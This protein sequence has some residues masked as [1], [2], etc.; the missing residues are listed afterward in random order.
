[1]IAKRFFAAFIL[2]FLFC[3]PLSAQISVPNYSFTGKEISDFKVKP[4]YTTVQFNFSM[5]NPI[6][7]Y[8]QKRQAELES[9]D[10]R[11]YSSEEPGFIYKDPNSARFTS[12]FIGN[13]ALRNNVV[14]LFLNKSYVDVVSSYERF[15][16]KLDNSEFADEVRFLYGVSLYYIGSQKDALQTLSKLAAGEGEYAELAQDALFTAAS[17]LKL[18]DVMENAASEIDKFTIFSLSKWLEYLYSKDRYEDILSLLNNY[19]KLEADYP[20]YKVMR[21]TCCYFLKRYGEMEKLAAEI[22]DK[23]VLP[24]IADAYIMSGKLDE[25]KKII[26]KMD[27]G[28]VKL[29]LSAKIDINNKNFKSASDKAAAMASDN[30]KLALFFYAVSERFKAI[31]PDF[32]HSFRFKN[33]ADNDYVYFYTGLKYF[34][35]K[36]YADAVHYFSLIGFNKSLMNTASFYKGMAGLHID[37]NISEW[38]FKK[39][40]NTGGDSDKIALAKFML[41]QIYYLKENYDD[42]LML[43]DD[44][45]EDYC[46]VLKADLYLAANNGEKAFE[47][48]KNR[49][50]DRSRLIKANVYYNDKKYKSALAE[51]VKIKKKNADS[52]YLLMMSLF[53]NKRLKDAEDV[54]KANKKDLRIFSN[55]VQQLILAGEGRKALAYMEGIDNLSPAFKL[56]RAKLLA[57]YNRLKEAKRDYNALIVDNVFIYEALSG[58]FEIAKKEKKGKDFVEEKLVYVEK[59]GD[60][61]NK[62]VLVAELASYALEADAPNAAIGYVNYFL[63]NYP[64]SERYS[65]VLRTR[66]KLFRFTGRFENC[67][68]D[69]D[70]IIAGGGEAGEDALFM[71]AECLENIDKNKAVETYKTVADT[72]KRF[73]VPALAKVAAM[74]NNAEDVFQASEKLKTSSPKQWRTGILRFMDLSGKKD[75]EKHKEYVEELSKSSLPAVR[76]AA[77]WRIGKDEFESGK[78]ADATVS[79]MK[80]YYLFPNEKYAVQNLQGAKAGY[81]KR[82]MK[83]ETEIVDKMLSKYNVKNEKNT[84]KNGIKGK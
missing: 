39:F 51:I 69:A 11:D 81:T 33:K 43:V 73:A 65:E 5:P 50:D 17:E 62:D 37:P 22:N 34:E 42:A 53:K 20:S 40:L 30:E 25:A 46:S 3:A 67:V 74:S 78:A 57:A 70:K 61:D 1:M 36:N 8:L 41:A 77:F 49:T 47:F 72:S 4:G 12:L 23:N 6:D 63:D 21:L 10:K 16:K 54:M 58:L 14:K 44:C 52:E 26:N 28:D 56:E 35:D 59:S 24:L 55:G 64:D 82:K 19:P 68:E 80:G 7:V 13:K 76:S 71:K 27:N 32:H 48:I 75:F 31:T 66:G 45:N 60:F 84:A 9:G 18:Y 83:K 2:S 38:N 15:A 29:L 79:F